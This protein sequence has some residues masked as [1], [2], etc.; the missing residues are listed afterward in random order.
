MRRGGGVIFILFLQ[1]N[2]FCMEG[3]VYRY[4]VAWEIYS[5]RE[6]QYPLY[7]SSTVLVII[8]MIR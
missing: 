5:E 8:M 1:Y 6:V 2:S 4:F 3:G 7:R